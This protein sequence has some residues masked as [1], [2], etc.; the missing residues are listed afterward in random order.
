LR[1]EIWEACLG[2]IDAHAIP[3]A[4]FAGA[5][6]LGPAHD[7]LGKGPAGV[8]L[9]PIPEITSKKRTID[10]GKEEEPEEGNQNASKK[11]KE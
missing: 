4:R 3:A 2:S 7:I 11:I 9:P 5:A 1:G 6:L 10:E 8:R